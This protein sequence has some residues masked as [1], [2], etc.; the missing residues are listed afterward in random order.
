MGTPPRF[1]STLKKDFGQFV[2][3]S[4]PKMPDGIKRL[5]S[6]TG[7]NPPTLGSGPHVSLPYTNRSM[8]F[9]SFGI[10]INPY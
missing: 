5:A 1:R 10:F 9:M 8:E 3:G 6:P 4:K 2:M 7:Q